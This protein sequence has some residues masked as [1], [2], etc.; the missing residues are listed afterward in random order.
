M[1]A[2]AFL[3]KVG[4]PEQLESIRLCSSCDF[5]RAS[6]P[7]L[8]LDVLTDY[9]PTHHFTWFLSHTVFKPHPSSWR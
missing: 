3:V 5:Q 1:S 4:A 6:A 7:Q 8:Q 9:L 2:L